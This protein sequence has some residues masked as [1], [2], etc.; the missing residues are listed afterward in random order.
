MNPDE[1]TTVLRV[2]SAGYPR[3]EWPE[4]HKR[5]WRAELAEL[6]ASEGMG[7]AQAMIRG[8]EFLS[9]AAFFAALAEVRERHADQQRGPNLEQPAL[10]PGPGG[11]TLSPEAIRARAEIAAWKDRMQAKSDRALADERRQRRR[12]WPIRESDFS[13]PEP[14]AAPDGGF[15]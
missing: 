2:L 10:P 5:L 1:C 13:P 6:G 12:P 8:R 4:D 7:A 11:G 14:K 3:H 15:T 9:F